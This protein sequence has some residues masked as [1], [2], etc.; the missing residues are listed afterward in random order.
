MLL[1]ERTR[2]A[3]NK[4]LSLGQEE[5][6]NWSSWQQ[7]IIPLRSEYIMTVNKMSE[8]CMRSGRWHSFTHPERRDSPPQPHSCLEKNDLTWLNECRPDWSLAVTKQNLV[9]LKTW[10]S[11][12]GFVLFFLHCLSSSTH[13]SRNTSHRINCVCFLGGSRQQV[14]GTPQKGF[15][16]PEQ[17][18]EGKVSWVLELCKFA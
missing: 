13:S 15:V 2:R 8:G 6:W 4:R 9:T 1:W 3:G 5:K 14:N 10:L 7:S 18:L 17:L 16:R 11:F 12:F